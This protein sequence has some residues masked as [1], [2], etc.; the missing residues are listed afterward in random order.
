MPL[1][2]S[3]PPKRRPR[4][5]APVAPPS[6]V[7]AELTN[8]PRYRVVRKL[9]EGGM[10][11][12]YL[13]E[14]RVMRQ[15]RAI[16]VLNKAMLASPAALDRFQAEVRAAAQLSH[17]NIAQAHDADQAGDLHFLVMEYVEGINLAQALAQ[18]GPLPVADACNYIHQAA[19]GLQHAFDKGMV[20]RDVKPQNLMLTPEGRVKVLDF[21]L[22]RMG[23]QRRRGLTA[24]GAFLG[25]PAYVAPEQAMDARTADTR[26]DVYSLG[27]T[28]YCLLAGRPPFVEE[29]PLNVIMAHVQQEPEPLHRLRP[30]VPR[31]LS[32]VVA[33]T[34]AKDPRDRYQ[35]P[36]EVA[37]A[38]APFARLAS[39]ARPSVSAPVPRAPEPSGTGTVA[40]SDTRQVPPAQRKPVSRPPRRVAAQPPVAPLARSGTEATPAEGEGSSGSAGGPG[41]SKLGLG[42]I[43]GTATLLIVLLGVGVLWLS[44]RGTEPAD[45]PRSAAARPPTHK[46]EA[47][48]HDAGAPQADHEKATPRVAPV[49]PKEEEE[50][51][52]PPKVAGPPPAVPQLPKERTGVLLVQGLQGG[53]GVFVD[54]KRAPDPDGGADGAARLDVN[55]GFH[56]LKVTRAGHRDWTREVPV[57]A[58][59]PATVTVR[60]ERLQGELVLEKLP[61]GARALLD[62]QEVRLKRGDNGTSDP[63]PLDTGAHELT[64][65]A[66]GFGDYT[67]KVTIEADKQVRHALA[68]VAAEA[69]NKN[70]N[71]INAGVAYLKSRQAPDGTWT[72][73]KD[74]PN[75]VGVTALCGLALLEAGIK[76]DDRVIRDAARAVREQSLVCTHTY[77][78]SLA[79]LFLDRVGDPADDELIASMAVRLLAGQDAT[80]GGWSYDCP[81]LAG[82]EVKRLQKQLF[83]RD[84]PA[85]LPAP[86]TGPRHR[87]ERRDLSPEIRQQADLIIRLLAQP[88][89]PAKASMGDNSNVHLAI[90]GLWV[91]RRQGI[92]IEAAAQR[93]NA[94][95]RLSQKPD[96]GW[97]YTPAEPPPK[98]NP[99]MTCAG[100]LGLAVGFGSNPK[101]AS[102]PPKDPAVSKALEYL[103][104]WMEEPGAAAKAGGLVGGVAPGRVPYYLWGLERVCQIYGVEKLDGKDWYAWGTKW[105][106]AN[107]KPDGSWEAEL[108]PVV[109]TAFVLLFLEHGDLVP[110]LTQQ[111]QLRAGQ[112]P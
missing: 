26:A 66:E 43:A 110:D 25:T 104:K 72:H 44:Q 58:G 78:L 69:P 98:T 56:Q 19:L 50:G 47:A 92:P 93:V 63:L 15:P 13:A 18:R 51:S 49:H 53:D 28:L 46:E 33:K 70:A 42:M 108:G 90:L 52:V 14:H 24:S 65:T 61:P 79:I 20:H 27:C 17:H 76:P 10:G 22:A 35:T 54:G 95:F 89:D 16:K 36:I 101:R 68:M 67:A 57:R 59:E 77:S 11:A 64:V 60:P 9:G 81:P 96:G 5:A 109:D 94:R 103:G 73:T 30:D 91:A 87:R 74:T 4:P 1:D 21:G 100:L 8:H 6:D 23:S 83:Q 75:T 3:P 7:P 82:D 71:L 88:H 80:Y 34:L 45:K 62:G 31:E 102:G 97:C 55:E 37:R 107:Q 99:S 41:R 40:A 106:T 86:P 84:G 111:H 112:L 105:A 85:G 38:L 2:P 12:V 29:M 32:A 39:K 48:P